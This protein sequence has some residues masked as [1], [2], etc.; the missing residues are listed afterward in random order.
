MPDQ[1]FYEYASKLADIVEL[2]FGKHLLSF[3]IT[4][5]MAYQIEAIICEELYCEGLYA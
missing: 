2:V 1:E 5:V 4:P 3:M